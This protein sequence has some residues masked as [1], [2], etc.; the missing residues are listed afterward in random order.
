[1]K[2]KLLFFLLITHFSFSQIEV[3]DVFEEMPLDSLIPLSLSNHTGIRPYIRINKHNKHKF[4][5]SGGIKK[6]S[7][8]LIH[9]T[10]LVDAGLETGST[11]SYRT[12]LGASITSNFKEKW[13]FKV[14]AIQ[15]LGETNSATFVPK[16]FYYKKNTGTNYS[17]TDVRGR[18]SYTPNHIFNFQ[19]GIDQNFIGEGNRS[20]LLSDYGKPYPFAQIRTRFGSFEYMMLY[21][22]LKERTYNQQWKAKYTSTHLMSYNVTNKISIGIFETV[23]FSPKDTTLNRGYDAEYLNPIVFFRPQEY[24]LGS[25]DNILLGAQ[26]SL[27][28]SKHTI[29][30]QIIIDE[31]LLSELR[32]RSRWWGNKYGG[33]LGIKGRILSNNQHYFYRI[34]SNFARPYTFAHKTSGQNYG[35]QGLPLAHPFGANFFE[36]LGEL[37]WQ[38]KKWSLKTFLNYYMRG[39][40]KNDNF[41]YG[42]D[43]YLS[44]NKYKQEYFNFIGNGIK[45]NGVQLIATTSYLIDKSSNLQ[46]F[47]ENH[48]SGN[49]LNKKANYQVVV[50]IRSCLWNDYRNY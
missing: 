1:M 15:G 9:I 11:G 31:F 30:G 24:S 34:E 8:H 19:A 10:P 16:S 27:K 37:K 6:D 28:H 21:Q 47:L 2:F 25:S 23:V 39:L 48:L 7:T 43:I 4:S 26:F 3:G 18:I 36:I 32:A 35:N 41:S 17:Y 49:T 44:Y 5:I 45:Q 12:G 22:F 50:G 33:Q 38:T 14:A 29:Y 46:V 20:M 40:E 13:Y 42:G